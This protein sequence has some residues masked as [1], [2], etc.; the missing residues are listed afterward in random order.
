LGSVVVRSFWGLNFSDIRQILGCS[1]ILSIRWVLGFFMVGDFNIIIISFCLYFFFI[2]GVF[3]F[4]SLV[5]I[6]RSSEDKVCFSMFLFGIIR[7]PCF[8]VFYIKFFLIMS[9]F[10]YEKVLFIY[11]I[12]YGGII[13][14][15]R[16][17]YLNWVNRGTSLVFSYNAKG[18]IMYFVMIGVFFI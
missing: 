7:L 8:I 5:N 18:I 3:F 16:L 9:L 2:I 1:S 4:S 13:I 15:I 10:S 11:L 12:R 14:Y 6:I 17:F